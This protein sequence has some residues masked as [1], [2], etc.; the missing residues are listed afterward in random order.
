M[1][2]SDSLLRCY[3]KTTKDLGLRIIK[4]RDNPDSDN[5]HDVRTTIRRLKALVDLFP[6]KIRK[7]K[8]FV[9][10]ISAYQKLFRSTTPIRDLDVVRISIGGHLKHSA[11]TNLVST[12]ENER[13]HLL[14]N[15]LRF[16]ETVQDLKPPD[17]D[18]RKISEKKI[19]KRRDKIVKRLLAKLQEELPVL[20][21][22]SQKMRELHDVRKECK[23]LR[24]TLE[25]FPSRTNEDL[26]KILEDWQTVLG[27]VRDIDVS[28]KFAARRGLSEDLGPALLELKISRDKMLG[29]FYSKAR[30]EETNL[31]SELT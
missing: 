22:D 7:E 24:Y 5:V 8:R 13:E 1:K 25:L 26:V 3:Q 6:K 4:F 2:D 11:A 27:K 31:L 29:A 9:E 30:L 16:L 19:V 15:S 12:I 28:E 17:L 23:R 18:K 21:S 20:L 14:S 10:Y